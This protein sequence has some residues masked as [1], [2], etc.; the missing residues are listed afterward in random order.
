MAVEPRWLGMA[1]KGLSRGTSRNSTRARGRA[2]ASTWALR[3]SNT[4]QPSP[5]PN[6]RAS[7]PAS[8]SR[9]AA[10]CSRLGP[11]SGRIEASRPAQTSCSRL[12][13]RCSARLRASHSFRAV[14]A[15]RPMAIAPSS[16]LGCSP[17][18]PM[19]SR[20][21]ASPCSGAVAP[22]RRGGR[23]RR[24]AGA[25][26]IRRGQRAE[27]AGWNRELTDGKPASQGNRGRRRWLSGRLDRWGSGPGPPGSAAAG[28]G[29]GPLG[30][31]RC[32]APG[33]S[34]RHGRAA[35]RSAH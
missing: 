6:S 29:R 31:V 25:M 19:A 2:A 4:G 13:S 1:L 9:I 10:A 14:R 32:P 24:R 23:D 16:R 33:R 5:S 35:G 34:C 18:S 27:T 12:T 11:S 8:A 20:A 7:R 3:R 26:A 17:V 22:P 28:P 21:I 15:P 30:S